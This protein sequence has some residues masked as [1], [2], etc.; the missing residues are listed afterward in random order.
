M[1][2]QRGHGSILSGFFRGFS[3]ELLDSLR[4]SSVYESFNVALSFSTE[5]VLEFSLIPE[6][7]SGFVNSSEDTGGPGS[8]WLFSVGFSPNVS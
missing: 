7:A 6:V 5:G 3:C 2:L 1:L 4:S 8:S